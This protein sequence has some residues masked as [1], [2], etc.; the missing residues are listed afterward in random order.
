MIRIQH[1]NNFFLIRINIVD[2]FYFHVLLVH[3]YNEYTSTFNYYFI[4]ISDLILSGIIS[5]YR[6]DVAIA[7]YRLFL[8]Y[9]LKH[10]SIHGTEIINK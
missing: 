9:Q 6:L 10:E 1:R 7:F 5:A 4:V 2:C 8:L 3:I